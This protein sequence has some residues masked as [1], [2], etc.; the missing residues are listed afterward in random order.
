[1][2]LCGSALPTDHHNGRSMTGPIILPEFDPFLI[3]FGGFGIRWY[4]LAYIG[5]LL[6][7]YW[8]LRREA[9]HPDAPLTAEA[10]DSLLNHVL[11]GV[12][13]GGR[14]GYVLF[15]NPAFFLANPVEIIKVWQGGMAFHG[16]LLGVSVAMWVFARRQNIHVLN[17]SDRV[18]MVTPIGL[19]LGRIS[20]FINGELQ[21]R[22]TEVPWAMVFANGDGLPRHPSQLYEAGLEGLALGLVMMFGAHRGWLQLRGRM[23]AMLLLGYGMVRFAVEYVREPDPQ[24]GLLLGIGTMGQ[25]LC[26]PMIMAGLY[27]IWWRA[28]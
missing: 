5:G 14:L 2:C 10:V 6:A 1:M 28:A 9:A 11:I 4:A 27:L 24:L 23:T 25:M 12:I 15:Y 19:F 13:L 26:L 21:G 22:V 20:N 17:V 8:I 3:N 18:A 7:G 16:G